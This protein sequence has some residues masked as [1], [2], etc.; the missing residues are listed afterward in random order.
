MLP[1]CPLCSVGTL[2]THA[3]CE[4]LATLCHN[5]FCAGG[6]SLTPRVGETHHANDCMRI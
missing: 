6:V 1:L 3:P 2:I 4:A 5:G